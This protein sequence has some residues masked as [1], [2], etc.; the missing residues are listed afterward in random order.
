MFAETITPIENFAIKVKI[1]LEF[2]KIKFTVSKFLDSKKVDKSEE[3]VEMF[4]KPSWKAY[5]EQLESGS[6]LSWVKVAEAIAYLCRG[7][8]SERYRHRKP[9]LKNTSLAIL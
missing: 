9:A 7:Y 3:D 5:K 4:L 8:L 1:S 2:N 6:K